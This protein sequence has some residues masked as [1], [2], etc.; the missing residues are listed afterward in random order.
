MPHRAMLLIC[1]LGLFA[2]A[3]PATAEV[4]R[5]EFASKQPFGT[6]RTGQYVIWQGKIDG[7]R[8]QAIVLARDAGIGG[9]S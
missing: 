7:T 2:A 6:F 5:I 1:L 9:P 4:T 3:R 8:A